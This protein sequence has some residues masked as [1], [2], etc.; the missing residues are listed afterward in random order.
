MMLPRIGIIAG[1]GVDAAAW[2][3][4]IQLPAAYD[5]RIIES[6]SS[7]SPHDLSGFVWLWKPSLPVEQYDAERAGLQE[8]VRSILGHRE[9]HLIPIVVAAV[10]P[11]HELNDEAKEQALGW[12][13]SV[14]EMLKKTYHQEL[15]GWVP[16]ALTDQS[17][18]M[19]QADRPDSG[20][21]LADA[22]TR[23]RTTIVLWQTRIRRQAECCLAIGIV[24]VILYFAML[25]MT[26]P[27]TNRKQVRTRSNDMLS[28]THQEW[29]YH[30]QDGRLLIESVQGR[31]FENLPA[32]EQTRFIEHLRWLPIALDWLKQKRSTREVIKLRSQATELLS[33]MES[34]VDIWTTRPVNSMVDLAALQANTRQLLDGAFDPRPPPT[35]LHQAAQRYWLNERTI[36]VKTLHGILAQQGPLPVKLAEANT[37]LQKSMAQAEACRVHA[38][39]IKNAWL[40]ELNT[41]HAW[42]EKLLAKPAESITIEELRK[43]DAPT[44]LREAAKIE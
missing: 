1:H 39:E 42:L 30:L 15:Q 18:V 23:L 34:L 44:L 11:L 17:R 21:H 9:N 13:K 37:T 26:F 36:F 31:T 10:E 16:T 7:V 6:T 8:W 2:R 35:T 4:H 5:W 24:L 3:E 28:W 14:Q 22:I 41:S 19:L 33:A 40:Q 25:F 20:Q 12:L 32:A 38:P 29:N 43:E 27:W